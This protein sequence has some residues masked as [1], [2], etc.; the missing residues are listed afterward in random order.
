LPGKTGVGKNDGMV[1]NNGRGNTFLEP[2][3]SKT[4]LTQNPVKSVL[5]SEGK[6]DHQRRDGS[7]G[8]R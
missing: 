4:K 6:Q 3:K 2:A 5:P 8:G 1:E 7:L